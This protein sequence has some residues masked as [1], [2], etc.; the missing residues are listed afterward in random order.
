MKLY[1]HLFQS[2]QWVSLL[3]YVSSSSFGLFLVRVSQKKRPNRRENNGG[4]GEKK[5]EVENTT[6]VSP[7]LILSAATFRTSRNINEQHT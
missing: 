2:T 3:A 5:D 1:S 4:G 7:R 6:F